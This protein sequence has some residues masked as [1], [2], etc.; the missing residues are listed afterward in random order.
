MQT[1]GEHE[2]WQNSKEAEEPV[3]SPPSQYAGYDM[4]ES[5]P[6]D[7]AVPRPE[8]TPLTWEASEYVHRE[9][10]FLWFAALGVVTLAL[11][12]AAWFLIK[13]WTFALL[14]LVMGAALGVYG[15]RPP[16]SLSYSLEY[17]SLKI[18]EK[19]YAYGQFKSFAIVQDG[20]L[21]YIMLLP[22][23]RFAPAVTLYFP[24]ENGEQIVDILGSVLPLE[25]R[26]LDFVDKAVRKLHF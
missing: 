6:D 5:A 22:V 2:Y 26:E 1:T 17:E 13:S 14:T 19:E 25:R 24:P 11:A 9:K 20:P 10:S 12:A 3:A 4:E 18:E 16:R 23:K 8:F 15:N 21:S 7:K